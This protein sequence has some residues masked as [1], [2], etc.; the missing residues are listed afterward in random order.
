MAHNKLSDRTC[1]T[2]R[3]GMHGDGGSLDLR[4]ASKTARSWVF[5][6]RVGEKRTELGLG[7]YPAVTLSQARQDAS[8]CRAARAQGITD[9]KSW[10]R[11]PRFRAKPFPNIRRRCRGD[12][13]G[14]VTGLDQ[15]ACCRIPKEPDG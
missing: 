3:P 15:Q 13:R 8:E 2:A 12:A 6:Y 4:V 14:K 9:L 10:R 5:L 1:R 7:P 11:Y